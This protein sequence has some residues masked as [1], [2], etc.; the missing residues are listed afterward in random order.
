MFKSVYTA[1]CERLRIG[2]GEID[3]GL[4][5]LGKFEA[6]AEELRTPIDAP[7]AQP[8]FAIFGTATELSAPFGF[9]L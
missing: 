5:G 3:F 8:W 1:V 7:G 4:R 9:V 6:K 2:S